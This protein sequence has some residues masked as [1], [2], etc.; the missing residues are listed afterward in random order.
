[1]QLAE[2]EIRCLCFKSRELFLSQPILL[3][4][5]AHSK[6]VVIYLSLFDFSSSLPFYYLYYIHRLG[7]IHG[8][9]YHLLRLF[10]YGGFLPESN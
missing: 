1:M 9:Y 10:E 3:E 4:F 8:Q 7:D 5:G 6:F 2:N